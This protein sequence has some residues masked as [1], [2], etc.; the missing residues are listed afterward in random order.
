MR[1]SKRPQSLRQLST[2]MLAVILGVILTVST[3]F[4]GA[5]NPVSAPPGV[6]AQEELQRLPLTALLQRQ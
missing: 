1:F 5:S 2:H 6:V 3:L 4:R